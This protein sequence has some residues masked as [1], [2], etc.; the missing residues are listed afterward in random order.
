M[1]EDKLRENLAMSLEE[2][3][4]AFWIMQRNHKQLFPNETKNKNTK[5]R[6]VFSKPEWI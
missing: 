1:E 2:R 6:I 4:D 5:K 3:W